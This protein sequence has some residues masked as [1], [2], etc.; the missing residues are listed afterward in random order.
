MDG[1][2]TGAGT[3]AAERDIEQ[4]ACVLTGYD[5][6]GFS[7][8]GELIVDLLRSGARGR[9]PVD[10]EPVPRPLGRKPGVSA[11]AR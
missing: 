8:V 7:S 1:Y 2:S 3:V 9:E 11:R 10:L 6:G 4:A 5:F